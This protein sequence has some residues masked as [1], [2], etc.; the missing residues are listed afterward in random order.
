M[1]AAAFTRT[2]WLARDQC[3]PFLTLAELI[4]VLVR[5]ARDSSR[6]SPPPIQHRHG[7]HRHRRHR[8]HALHR[9]GRLMAATAVSVTATASYR[10]PRTAHPFST[11]A[12]SEHI[13]NSYALPPVRGRASGTARTWHR[14]PTALL[15]IASRSPWLPLPSAAPPSLTLNT[16]T[17][18]ALFSSTHGVSTCV[19]CCRTPNLATCNR[20]PATSL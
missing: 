16:Q 6:A 2:S 19:V 4:P 12:R 15:A 7:R 8:L 13:R 17:P 20:S 9:R 1:V 3:K 10:L 14:L 11:P 18:H 5:S